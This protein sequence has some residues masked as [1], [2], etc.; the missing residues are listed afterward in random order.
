MRR[1]LVTACLAVTVLAGGSANAF[2][3]HAV[4][5]G[6]LRL[7]IGEV[8]PVTALDAPQ[9]VPVA[10]GNTGRSPLTV[11]LR[12]L[13]LV[14]EWR[15]VGPAE[16][17]VE[18]PAGR[19]T[20]S[21]F[22]ISAGKGTH[23][24]LYPV[25]VTATFDR[26][27]R[28]ATA[29]AI[30]VFEA[31]IATPM[32]NR[33]LS[34]VSV[35]AHAALSLA[36]GRSHRVVWQYYDGAPVTLPVGW[37]GSAPRSSATFQIQQVTRGTTRRAIHMHPPWKPRGGS[38]FAEY[39][40]KLPEAGPIE[41]TFANAIRDHR[42]D[43]P[44]SDGV[45]F[46]VWANDQKLFERHT[47]SKT[48]VAGKADLSE[49]AGKEV[50]LRLESHPGPERNTTCDS[51]YWA[52]PVVT[53]GKPPVATSD[54]EWK[55]RRELAR[56]IV[57]GEKREDAL[58]FD[59]QG[60][61]RVAVVKGRSGLADAAIAIGKGTK[62]VVFDGIRMAVLG[63]AVGRWPSRASLTSI[64][65]VTKGDH[66][67][68]RHFCT[69]DGKRFELTAELWAEGPGLRI[70][71]ACPRRITD[72]SLGPADRKAP[73]VYYGHGYCIV[74]PKA[75]RAGFG[76][77]NLSTSHVGFD[78]DN[79]V[80]LLTAS[81]HPPDFLQ[82]DPT[83]RTY[84]LHTHHDA[85]L[86]LVAGTTSA[87]DC[88][89][90]YRPLY[91]KSAAGGVKRKAGRFV[92]DI[93][94]GRYAEIAQTM[95]RMIAYGLTDSLLTVHAW[96]RWGYDYRL[97]DIYPPDP[98]LG[99]VEDMRKIAAVC[100]AADIPWGLH[101]NYIDFY[102][103][104]AGYSYDHVCFNKAGRPVK[105]WINRSRDAQSY[106]WRPDAFRPFLE[107]NLKL[108]KPGVAPTHYFI[109][110][111]TSIGPFDYWDR[112]GTFH[113]MLETRRCWGEAFAW[114]RDYLGGQAPTTSE[115]GHDQLVGYLD[116]ADCQ[117]LELSPVGRRFQ[118]HLPCADWQRT[119]WFDAVLHEKFSLHG[120]GYS[121]RYE[122]GRPRRHHGIESDDYVSAE[123]LAGHALMIDRGGFGR[124]AVRKYWLAQD[125]IRS[126]AADRIASVTFAEG[127]IHRQIVRWASGATVHVNRGTKDW[128]VAGRVL[129]QYGYLAT[130]G[131]IRSSIERIDGILV[132]QSAAPGRQYV[133]A[134]GFDPTQ[135]LRIRP[136][137]ERVEDLGGGRIKLIVTWQVEAPAPKDLAIF[138]HFTSAK[139]K[140]SDEIAF[141]GD[142]TPAMGTSRWKGVVT[143][144]A[145]R[146]V[147]IPADASGEY[148]IG[149]GLWDPVAGRRY[150]LEGTNEGSLRYTLGKLVVVRAG[151]K[152][153]KV[154][155][156][157]HHATPSPPAR[158]N[159][160]G[161]LVDFGDIV[162][163]GALRC[164]A[165]DGGFLVTPLPDTEPF[166]VALRLD[167]LT[168]KASSRAAGV[169]AVAPDG[170]S[171]RKVA[172][173]A[174]DGRV[175]FTTR[176]G[177][178]AYRVSLTAG[179]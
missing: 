86:T 35:P 161:K 11:R 151:G 148:G 8:A 2:N 154:R 40:L 59:L 91:D 157:K 10:V 30:R 119:P 178:F 85:T 172:F 76:G 81:N 146:V 109:D 19:S 53:A 45:T 32:A 177:E 95:K 47:A 46:R 139:A 170:R 66:R 114:I 4:T 168:D 115:A 122:G 123:L 153:S 61:T 127:D 71:F 158:W 87:F 140:R 94:G 62:S 149:I 99:T 113:S 23:S 174:K 100:K 60:G 74:E 126:L 18:V 138:L 73:R 3:G 98:G 106:R 89:V 57:A 5:E 130:N 134:R 26:D 44:A 83:T 15:V 132:E 28:S 107:R 25:H 163:A 56:R 65:I 84:A 92:F 21:T 82:V 93:W 16:R 111:F 43:E 169:V 14:D 164:E 64:G 39:R 49:F 124:G 1:H 77:H 36:A 7:T 121:S 104:A 131:A 120:V 55:A 67:Q 143:T 13:G 6:P 155:L 137:A 34:L 166:V 142:L 135:G 22:R 79:G 176:K 118:I 147:Q 20:K 175:K 167:R 117:H 50:L 63:E 141:Q 78:F 88:A 42:A 173:A 72:L 129:P 97:P 9:T 29:R 105:A 51:S 160:T 31:R 27:G 54:A 69:L 37:V 159:V 133:N 38:I 70:R 108:I 171:V 103:D 102:P 145:N 116:G 150:A 96:Q 165:T 156:V 48:W 58:T 12:V 162:T 128:S 179:R 152:V 41:L 24:A 110:V 52:D 90:R 33:D 136:R 80:S 125:V 144:G 75:F 101:D 68:V 112:R 17:R